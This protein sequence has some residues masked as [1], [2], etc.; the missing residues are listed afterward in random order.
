MTL[1]LIYLLGAIAV[2][3]LC[4][5]LEAVL[6]STPIS[7]ITMREDEGYK[8]ASLF[9]QYKTD[10]ARP[11]AAIL[12]LNTIANTIGSAGVG[13]QVTAQFGSQWFGLA[14]AIM[15]L[16]ILVFSEIIPKTIGSTYWKRF[17][18]FTAYTIRILI[19]VMYPLVV[20]VDL[21]SQLLRKKDDEAAVSRE[22]VAAMADVGEDEGVI[23]EDENKIIQNVIKLDNIKAHD[24]M[25]PRVVA[26]TAPENMTLKTFYRNNTFSHFSRIP[27]YAE[28][29]EYITGYVLRSEALEELAEDH[30]DKTLGSIKRDIPLFNEQMSVSDIWDSLLKHK[31]QIAG[32]IDEYGCFEGILTLEDIIETI[33]GLEIIDESDEVSDMQQYARDRWQQ[34]QNR[35]KEIHLPMDD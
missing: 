5:I 6:M 32:I 22:E 35:F 30:F 10:N 21:I 9:K 27:V 8:P 17:M 12:S 3:F 7:Y 33:F 31:E 16:S 4:S 13:A 25:T 24:V 34:R 29:P 18:G 14:S 28:S 15:T 11:I 19:V 23:D 20:L 2:S 1:L 26:A